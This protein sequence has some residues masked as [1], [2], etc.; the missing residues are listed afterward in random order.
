MATKDEKNI[1]QSMGRRVKE[2]R[3]TAKTARQ[4][5][6]AEVKEKNRD[7]KGKKNKGG[8]LRASQKFQKGFGSF[9]ELPAPL[10]PLVALVAY[11]VGRNTWEKKQQKVDLEEARRFLNESRGFR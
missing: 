4:L 5:I 9:F 7:K 10:W 11:Q 1:A 8:V 3:K 2:E 6:K